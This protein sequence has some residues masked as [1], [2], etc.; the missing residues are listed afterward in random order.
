MIS[1]IHFIS[2]SRRLAEADKTV[3]MMG[4]K[5]QAPP[6]ILAQRDMIK[7]EKDYY[8]DKMIDMI[9]IL[10]FILVLS[11]IGTFIYKMTHGG[12]Q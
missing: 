5:N 12:F 1:I 2:A 11:G 8:Y 6:M 4:G 9:F 10:L 3:Y 7:L